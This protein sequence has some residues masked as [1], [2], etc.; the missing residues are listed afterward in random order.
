MRTLILGL[1]NTLLSDE[2]IGIHAIQYLQRQPNDLRDVDILDGGT[3][4][5]T[6][7]API[8]EADNLIVIDATELGERPGSVRTFV[9]EEMDGFLNCHK[10][11]SVHEVGLIDLMTIARLSGRLPLRRAL[12]AIQPAF[13]DWGDKPTA[14]VAASLPLACDRVLD[15]VRDWH[16]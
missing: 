2:G 1:G 3:L 5:F 10:K 13:L 9:G 15:L 16:Q 11:C 12:V 7:A 8:E 14:A 4:S 6:L